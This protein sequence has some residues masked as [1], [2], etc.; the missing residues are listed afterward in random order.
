V[1][2]TINTR[3]LEDHDVE[4]VLDLLRAAL[5]EPPLLRRT[6]ELLAWKHFDNPFGRSVALLAEAGHRI[7]GLRTF[8][9]WDLAA[10]DG[11]I[12]RCVRAVDTATHPEFHRRGIFRRLTEEAL[13]VASA[14][15]IDLVFNTPNEKSGAGYL[16]MGWREVGPV[17]VMVRPSL[18]LFSKARDDDATDPGRFIHDPVPAGPLELPDREPVGLRTPRTD[19]YRR[20]RFGSHPTAWYYQ[21]EAEGSVAVVRPNVRNGRRELVLADVFGHKPGRA[22]RKCARHSR[23]AYLAGWFSPGSPDRGAA[24]RSGLLPVPGLRPLTLMARPLGDLDID[25]FDMA[26]WDL[27]VSDLELL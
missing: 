10:V 20:W 14:Q 11:S 24:I 8:M 22:I 13:E 19:A 21:V 27:A 3:A 23:A 17:G 18:R 6:P 12:I 26:N 2:D 5:G 15:G 1:S 4:P 25:V 7:V 16:K 9:R